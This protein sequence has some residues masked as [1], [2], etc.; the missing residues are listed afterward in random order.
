MKPVQTV[1]LASFMAM[2]AVTPSLAADQWAAKTVKTVCSKCH[3][4]DGAGNSPMFPRL[5]GQQE[6]YLL[7]QL[8]L[9]RA[10]SR[11]D[12]HAR[13]YM[14][15]ISSP[16]NDQQIGQLAHYL[17]TRK[18][19]KPTPPENP[20]L[21]KA[22][23]EIFE[24]GVPARS[25]PACRDCH[26]AEGTGMLEIPRLAGQYRDYLYRAI[27][28]FRGLLRRSDIMHDQTKS[29]TDEEALAVAEY[30]SSR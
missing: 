2:V 9:F 17:A 25:V 23:E 12:A 15:G 29:I 10:R 18:P 16:L 24:K 28:E 8:V 19:A 7:H 13:A 27:Q 4:P 1:F 3:G 11:A 20:Q 14:W 21:A 5:A 22:G 6:A 26:G 30:M